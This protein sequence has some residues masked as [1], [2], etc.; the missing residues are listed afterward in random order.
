MHCNKNAIELRGLSYAYPD[1]TAALDN[2]SVTIRHTER[3]A[4]LGPNGAGKST[5]IG[6][7]NGITQAQTGTVLIDDEPI[8]PATL[9][10]VRERV[11]I[12]FQDP[13]D[14]LFMTTIYDDVA[15]G[16]R[17]M[18]LT[19]DTVDSRVQQTLAAVGL[20]AL[21]QKPGMHL[22]FGQKK[23]AALASVLSMQPA[24]LVLDEPTSNLD[25][26]ARRAMIDFLKQL[27]VTLLLATHDLDL[28]WE[29]TS[30]ALVLDAGHLVADGPTHDLM[31]DADLMRTHGLD[32]PPLATR[33]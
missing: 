20:D 4:L 15:F 5:L 25:P 6:H 29:L 16:P 12:V 31:R 19:A 23:R 22:S 8:T 26:R 7:L 27:D 32:T 11:G 2:L 1:G 33:P 21:L 28:A 18:G 9:K 24:I 14:M 30:R 3:V 13:D 10:S 17:N